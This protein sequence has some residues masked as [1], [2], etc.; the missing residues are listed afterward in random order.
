MRKYR[1]LIMISTMLMGCATNNVKYANL[2]YYEDG[3]TEKSVHI[4]DPDPD[5]VGN[6]VYWEWDIEGVLIRVEFDDGSFIVF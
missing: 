5:V 1:W 4:P 6:E 2:Q 3:M